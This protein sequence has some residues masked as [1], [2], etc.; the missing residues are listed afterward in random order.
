MLENAFFSS[1][2]ENKRCRTGHERSSDG[3]KKIN[4]SARFREKEVGVEL[5][6]YRVERAKTQRCDVLQ[7]RE[8]IENRKK[9]R[10]TS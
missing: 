7:G 5:Y 2:K 3:I 10:K 8:K 9:V 6:E 1:I 4:E